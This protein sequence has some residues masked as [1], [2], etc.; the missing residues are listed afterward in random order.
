MN[1]QNPPDNPSCDNELSLEQLVLQETIVSAI[2]LNANSV[3]ISL[4]GDPSLRE[5]SLERKRY[6]SPIDPVM[7]DLLHSLEELLLRRGIYRTYVGFNSGEVRTYSIFD[8]L[9]V[10]THSG[11]K[12]ARLD[13]IER[14][15]P[16]IGYEEKVRF[17]R[18]LY[19]FLLQCEIFHQLPEHWKSIFD[20]RHAS[21]QPMAQEEIRTIVH[22]F[23]ILRN[24]PELYLRN[25]TLCIVQHLAR[26]QFNCDG[27][28]IISAENYQRFLRENIL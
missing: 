4:K 28:Q 2:G 18:K 26:L 13:Y 5:T 9:R 6:E 24:L 23:Q 8:P 1:I 17:M 16:L 15:F 21:W 20:K 14:H 7:P 25:A 27:A 11:V 12:L 22:S 19:D 3:Q 10:E